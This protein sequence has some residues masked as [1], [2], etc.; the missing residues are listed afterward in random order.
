MEVWIE[1]LL[2][3]LLLVATTDTL[4][5]QEAT[6]DGI[7]QSTVQEVDHDH[8]RRLARPTC[9]DGTCRKTCGD[10][11]PGNDCST[12]KADCGD[13]GCPSSGPFCGDGTCDNG[14]DCSNC[15]TDC[16]GIACPTLC[17]TCASNPSRSCSKD[18]DCPV[19]GTCDPRCLNSDGSSCKGDPCSSN[20]DCLP[21]RGKDQ[22]RCTGST[23]TCS[24][25]STCPLVTSP[26]CIGGGYSCLQ[27]FEWGELD[28]SKWNMD[29]QLESLNPTLTSSAYTTARFKWMSLIIGN[30]YS[31]GTSGMQADWCT[32]PY[33]ATIDDLHVCGRD[34]YID[35]PGG[36]LGR[37]GPFYYRGGTG[38]AINGVMEFDIDDIASLVSGGTWEGVILHEMGHIIGIGTLWDDAGFVGPSDQGYPYSGTKGLEVWQN[39]WSCN[40][41]PPV[42]TD[43]N[44]G[45][46]GGHWDEVCMG[47]ELMTGY[48]G[49]ASDLPCSKLTAAA[50]VDLGYTVDYTSLFIDAGYTGSSTSCCTNLRN[51]RKNGAKNLGKGRAPAS[52]G[53]VANARAYGVKGLVKDALKPGLQRVTADGAVYVGDQKTTVFFTENGEIYSIDVK[54]ADIDD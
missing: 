40:G 14:E 27:N 6:Y 36:I 15:V 26:S 2:L 8:L 46:A 42:E 35:G 7:A 19:I 9:T 44:P 21:N 17:G 23:D 41:S 5:Q 52:P 4:A 54:A 12:F 29:I 39:E 45:T 25:L 22:S 32:N 34:A 24:N 49:G 28:S 10:C 3:M 13:I 20:G 48:L 53:A 50:L 18:S 11:C 31:V 38:T 51:L 16:N 47:N 1:L 37:A 43:G 33:P 30:L